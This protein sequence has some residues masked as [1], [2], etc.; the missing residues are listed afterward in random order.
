MNEGVSWSWLL[1]FWLGAYHGINPGM[2]WLFAVAL[3]MQEKSGRAVGRALL[4]IALGHALAIGVVVALAGVVGLVLPLGIL[5][6]GVALTLFAFG[7]YYLV[8]ARHP[9]WGGMRVGFAD[10]TFWS[11]LMASA[12]GAGFMVLPILFGLSAENRA[13][14]SH[15]PEHYLLM[16]SLGPWTGLAA[17]LVHAAG[18]LLATGLAAWIVYQRLRLGFLRRAW[19]NLD[20]IWAV[21]L[22]ATGLLTLLI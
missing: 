20:W 4:P 5:K 7:L 10:L 12:H 11:F 13:H 9:R 18:Y 6:I 3:G 2:G 15:A 17:A 19:I 14:H 8:R 16:S 21:A 22:T 1:L